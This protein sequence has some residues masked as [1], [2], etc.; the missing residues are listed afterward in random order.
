MPGRTTTNRQRDLRR[1]EV[2]DALVSGKWNARTRDDLCT[3]HKVGENT[4]YADY[5][6]VMARVRRPKTIARTDEEE[7]E[8][9]LLRLRDVQNE[10]RTEKRFGP[11][12]TLLA[13]EA[14]VLG[15]A[16]PVRINV[17]H[18]GAVGVTVAQLSD[19]DLRLR[20]EELRAKT[21]GLLSGPSPQIIDADYS[22]VPASTVDR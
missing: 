5:K 17:H 19:D 11:L 9:F 6:W 12:A 21:A 10:A 20:V 14:R 1:R 15:V 7:R 16:E 18:G 4:I 22:T 2:Y 3:K 13:L 8:L